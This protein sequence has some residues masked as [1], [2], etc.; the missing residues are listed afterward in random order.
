MTKKQTI[1]IFFTIDEGYAPYFSVALASLIDHANNDNKYVIHVIHQELS[2]KTLNKLSSLKTSNISIKFT[3]IKD[4][5]EPVKEKLSKKLSLTH[6][7]IS[8]YFRIFIPFMFPNYDKGIYID[9]DTV[10]NADITELFNIDLK[11][12]L[13]GGCIDKSVIDT[14]F[15]DYFEEYV[16]ISR[17]K[18]INSGVLLMNMKKL[19]EIEFETHFLYLLN[20]YDFDVI[21]PDQAYINAMCKD[22]ILYIEDAWDAMP[23]QGKKCIKNPKLIHYNLFL[24]PWHYDDIAYEEYFWKYANES[25][26]KDEIIKEKEYYTEAKKNKDSETL[27]NMVKHA[28]ELIDS[29]SSFKKVFENNKESRL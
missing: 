28:I 20:K 29:D 7:P 16:G 10:L 8:I 2:K 24:K 9:S 21:D 27:Q 3:N 5:I 4:I 6:W 18:Y 14:P 17:H 26:F 13:I 15:A 23:V 1:P 22:N 11:N 19:R 25:L 12:N